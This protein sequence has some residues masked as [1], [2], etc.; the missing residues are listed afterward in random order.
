VL[1]NFYDFRNNLLGREGRTFLTGRIWNYIYMCTASA[2]LKTKNSLV[3]F[4]RYV[5]EYTICSLVGKFV[6]HNLTNASN[7]KM[8]Y[9]CKICNFVID[10]EFVLHNMQNED[11]MFSHARILRNVYR[12]LHLFHVNRHEWMEAWMTFISTLFPCE[13]RVLRTHTWEEWR[14]FGIATSS[15]HDLLL[16]GYRSAAWI[17]MRL[18]SSFALYI[19]TMH[20]LCSLT[21][22][23]DR[24]KF[25][26]GY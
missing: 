10:L 26:G 25:Y 23:R 14:G 15:D 21:V 3:K 2:V 6:Y 20:R 1:P 8:I 17:H 5:T 22:R 18:T 11:E 19:Q 12:M 4:V 16:L 9:R 24:S 13:R 7:D